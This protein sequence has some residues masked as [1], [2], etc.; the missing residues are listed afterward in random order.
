MTVIVIIDG[1]KGLED[2]ENENECSPRRIAVTRKR[3]KANQEAGN[4]T[5]QS[6]A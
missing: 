1:G 5:Q 2:N 4:R 3:G 6:T